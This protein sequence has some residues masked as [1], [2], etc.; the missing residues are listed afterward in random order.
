M[1]LYTKITAKITNT[2]NGEDLCPKK[3]RA[4]TEFIP[5][6]N[7][8]FCTNNIRTVRETIAGDALLISSVSNTTLTSSVK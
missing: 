4:G 5:A 7:T 2:E 8:S 1:Y 3:Y 6:T